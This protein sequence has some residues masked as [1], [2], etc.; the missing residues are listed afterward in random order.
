MDAICARSRGFLSLLRQATILFINKAEA[1]ALT[2]LDRSVLPEQLVSALKRLGPEIACLT[3]GESGA[4]VAANN[5]V[6]S[7]Q[8]LVDK[9][10]LVDATG[11]GD[12]FTSGFL[13]GYLLSKNLNQDDRLRKAL[14]FATANS[15]SVVV[16]IGAQ[17]GLLDAQIAEKDGQSVKIRQIGH[18]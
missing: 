14:Q 7:A 1:L 8:A 6:L 10:N 15:G 4:Y 18:D 17:A 16:A 2:R 9:G 5:Q 12:A 11:A 3:C 13:G